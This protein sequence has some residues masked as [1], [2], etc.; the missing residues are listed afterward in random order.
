[1]GETR[2]DLVHLLQDLRE[3]Y[4]GSIEE[5]IITEMVANALVFADRGDDAQAIQHLETA[6]AVWQNA[7]PGYQPALKAREQLAALRPSQ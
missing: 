4:P 1:L 3:A 2:V 5:T 6:L 7:D